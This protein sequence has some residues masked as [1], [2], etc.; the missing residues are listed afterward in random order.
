MKA[1]ELIERVKSE[2]R[3][4]LNE[5]EAKQLL[6]CYGV[7]VVEETVV[8]TLDDAVAQAQITGF[9][10]VLKGLGSRLTH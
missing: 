8:E 7:P 1:A 2:G 3:T 6:R 10:V 9:P 5:A 4:T